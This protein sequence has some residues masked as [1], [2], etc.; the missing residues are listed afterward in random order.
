[1]NSTYLLNI[2]ICLAYNLECA[3]TDCRPLKIL[4]LMEIKVKILIACL[5]FTPEVLMELL[6][7]I[8]GILLSKLELL[9]MIK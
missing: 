5:A 6:K 4:K 7:N 9:N 1:V 2:I 8:V 3:L